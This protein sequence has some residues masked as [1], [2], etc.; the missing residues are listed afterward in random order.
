MGFFSSSR[1][2]LLFRALFLAVLFLSSFFHSPRAAGQWNPLNPVQS[3]Q[4][5]AD[6]L[7]VFLARG[8]LRFEVC[9]EEMVRVLYSPGRDFP[10]VAEYVVIKTDWPKTEFAVSENEKEIT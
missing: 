4:K 7:T 10:V 1:S 6:G 2:H 5:N 9:R 3:I 8:A